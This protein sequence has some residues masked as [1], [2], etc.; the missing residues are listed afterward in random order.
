[1]NHKDYVFISLE[2][3]AKKA[4][5]VANDFLIKAKSAMGLIYRD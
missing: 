2:Q 3:G 1:M 5:G 4:S